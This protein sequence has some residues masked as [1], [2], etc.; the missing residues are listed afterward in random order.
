MTDAAYPGNGS[1][2]LLRAT[3]TEV[4]AARDGN[5][6][7]AADPCRWSTDAVWDLD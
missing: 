6:G 1:S 5:Q 2:T 4:D 7:L 3:A